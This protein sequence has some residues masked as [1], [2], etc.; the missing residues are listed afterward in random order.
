MHRCLG[1]FTAITS[2]SRLS[3]LHLW[4]N[5]TPALPAHTGS[6]NTILF[7]VCTHL[8]HWVLRAT[9]Q[10]L[11]LYVLVLCFVLFS[12]SQVFIQ[13]SK[14]PYF[15]GMNILFCVNTIVCMS[16]C[17]S[18]C[19]STHP[20]PYP[21]IHIHTLVSSLLFGYYKLCCC[22][23]M[24]VDTWFSSCL[25]QFIWEFTQKWTAKT[26]KNSVFNFFFLRTLQS[27]FHSGYNILHSHQQCTR[28]PTFPRVQH[29]RIV[30]INGCE[31]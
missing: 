13:V 28:I 31:H 25:L 11:P 6:D 10:C 8:T 5:A 12:P 17:L 9:V 3:S 18:F 23:L 30:M 1:L 24:S 21:S 19:P 26:N 4:S 16:I 15:L 7:H 29:L 14:C 22:K 20:S 2:P 27:G